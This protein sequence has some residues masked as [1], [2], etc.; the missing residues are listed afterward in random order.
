MTY[1]IFGTTQFS[2]VRGSFDMLK[3]VLYNADDYIG[4]QVTVRYQNK[5]DDGKLRFPVVVAF[6]KDKRDL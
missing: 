5:T 3:D 2:G 4:G 1:S 6:W